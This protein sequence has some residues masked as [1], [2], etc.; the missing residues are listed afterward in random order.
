MTRAPRWLLVGLVAW[1]GCAPAPDAD[2]PARFVEKEHFPAAAATQ[3]VAVDAEHFYAITTRAIEKRRR[4]DGGLVARWEARPEDAVVH[5]NAGIVIDG[6]LHCA[7]SNYPGVPMRSSVLR[8]DPADLS[9]LGR[10][11]LPGAPGSLTWLD[12]RDG[13]WWAAFAH[14]AGR[15]GVPGKGPADT[16]VVRF[17]AEWRPIAS[18]AFPPEVVVRFGTRSS[19][20]GGF[21]PDGLLWATGHDAAELYALRIP[22]TGAAL[23]WVAT[24]PAPIAGQGIAWDPAEPGA[25]WGI[26]RG[27]RLVRKME[28]AG[29]R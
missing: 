22:E 13:E 18:Y 16:R 21:G 3:G 24:W 5:L 29:S 9:L 4:T 23:E 28:R 11:A 27:L 17:D 26:V 15:G 19:S 12:R 6:V 8:F 20:G 2:S 25:L 7:H 10:H 1:A 14:Y